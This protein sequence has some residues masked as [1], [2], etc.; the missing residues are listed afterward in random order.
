MATI[1]T[2]IDMPELA[3]NKRARF[4]YEILD[5]FEAGIVLSGQ[6]VKSV[7]EGKMALL[8]SHAVIIR[9]ELVLIG[10][11]IPV[12]KAAGPQPDYDPKRTRTL[13]VRKAELAKIAGKLEVKGLTIVPISAYTK[14]TKI[15]ISLG[16]GR[17]KRE[18]DKRATI[19]KRD[20]DRDI[21]RSLE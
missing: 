15:K 21:R 14:G 17:G 9:G 7:R 10:A 12:Y 13:L 5:S 20:L 8:G 6:E 4:D 16:L 1:S 18:F 3:F 11:Q 2:L 19:K